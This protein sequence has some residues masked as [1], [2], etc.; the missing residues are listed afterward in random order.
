MADSHTLDHA[1]SHTLDRTASLARHVWLCLCRPSDVRNVAGAIR[2]AANFGVAGVKLISDDPALSK[3]DDLFAFSSG[4]SAVVDLRVYSDLT[5]ALEGST[6]NVG[7]S[8]R[9][10]DHAHLIS[11]ETLDL[12]YALSGHDAPHIL[13]GNERFGLSR[14]ELDL[15]QAIVTL[16]SQEAFPSL[17]LA[18]AVA[19]VAYEIARGDEALKAGLSDQGETQENNVHL[20]PRPL[21]KASASAAAEEAFLQRVIEVSDRVGYPPSKSSERF[22]RQLR[23]LLK[24]AHA[25]PGDY[26]LV[27]GIFRELDRLSR[28]CESDDITCIDD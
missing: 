15:C 18:H 20:T 22:A 8:R 25:T 7:T 26:G 12:Y 13:F 21:P 10:R 6:I 14:V 19:C 11:L 5:A 16:P 9:Q 28:L 4:A 2:A 23:S 17:N 24:R 1:Q 3:S 27:L